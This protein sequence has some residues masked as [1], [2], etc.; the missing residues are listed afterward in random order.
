MGKIIW[1]LITD[2]LGSFIRS[3]IPGVYSLHTIDAHYITGVWSAAQVRSRD[4]AV[5]RL[6]YRHN[7]RY[8]D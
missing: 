8:P 6:S 7:D 2:K 1:R 3:N 4:V 5:R